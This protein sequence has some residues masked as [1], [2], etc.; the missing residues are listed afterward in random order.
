MTAS[1]PVTTEPAA[2]RPPRRRRTPGKR[3]SLFPVK[4]ATWNYLN[5]S[6]LCEDVAAARETDR[7]L[8][9]YGYELIRVENPSIGLYVFHYL[10]VD[11]TN[12]GRKGGSN[13]F[14]DLVFWDRTG[15]NNLRFAVMYREPGET[16]W[17]VYQPVSGQRLFHGE[18]NAQLS[19]LDCREAHFDAVIR[20]WPTLLEA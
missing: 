16:A 13:E 18:H 10:D 15:G 5:M 19:E 12:H 9:A 4:G 2:T 3:A 14:V 1:E 7:I 11:G 8:C 17:Q 6:V 20:I